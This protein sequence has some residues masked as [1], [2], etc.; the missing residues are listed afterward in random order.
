MPL[1]NPVPD[2]FAAIASKM[3]G[4]T[5]QVESTGGAAGSSGN[6]PDAGHSHPRLTSTT[7]ATIA[8]GSTAKVMFTRTFTKQ[9]GIDCQLIETDTAAQQPVLFACT[10][11]WA[12]NGTTSLGTNPADG[13]AIGGVTIKAWRATPIPQNLVTLLAGAVWSLFGGSVVGIRFSCIAV[14]RSDP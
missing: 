4:S 9:P 3:S 13:T 12:P 6:I 14:A 1:F 2:V 10:E 8:A 7:Y 11:W 5:P